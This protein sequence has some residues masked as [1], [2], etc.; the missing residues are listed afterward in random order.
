MLQHLTSNDS[1]GWAFQLAEIHAWLGE[2]DK[3]FEA[4]EAAY[5]NKD[6]GFTPDA[7]LPIPGLSLQRSALGANPGQ[8]W[9][10]EILAGITNPTKT[11]RTVGAASRGEASWPVWKPDIVAAGRGSYGSV[12]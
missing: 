3:A 2:P 9:T 8:G 11:G 10:V 6:G 12:G 4:L 1:D 5:R 7:L